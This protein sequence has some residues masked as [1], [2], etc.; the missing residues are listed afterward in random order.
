M[1]FVNN[2]S[3]SK[4]RW[5]HHFVVRYQD[6]DRPAFH[7]TVEVAGPLLL[8]ARSE[9]IPGTCRWDRRIKKNEHE[10]RSQEKDQFN[11]LYRH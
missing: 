5:K 6:A 10:A 4:A 8:Q 9:L 3:V 7:N 2:L 1:Y 11:P